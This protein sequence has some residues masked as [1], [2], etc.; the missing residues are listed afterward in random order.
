MNINIVAAYKNIKLLEQMR[1]VDH[2]ER[3]FECFLKG[4][5]NYFTSRREMR[6]LG[7]TM[8]STLPQDFET[9][10]PRTQPSAQSA[11]DRHVSL[12]EVLKGE[13]TYIMDP[14]SSRLHNGEA[15]YSL[16][17]RPR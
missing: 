11:I 15:L 8:T 1:C 12:C 3:I 4:T 7:I 13:I 6:A 17:G 9:L 14:D 2:V 10:N 5:K 16:N